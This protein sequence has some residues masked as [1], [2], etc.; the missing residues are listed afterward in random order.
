MVQCNSCRNVSI[1]HLHSYAIYRQ[2][3]LKVTFF[4]T[5]KILL[6]TRIIVGKSGQWM[7]C[8][9]ER[10]FA[11]FLV[12]LW[13]S[14]MHVIGRAKSVEEGRSREEN[15]MWQKMNCL[16]FLKDLKRS[17]V[18]RLTSIYINAYIT[19]WKRLI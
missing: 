12:K 4:S 11:T 16:S 15:Y 3:P 5:H 18:I 1:Q 2:K 14:K 6:S 10:Q 9:Y 8:Y 19:L 7:T 13:G 17:R